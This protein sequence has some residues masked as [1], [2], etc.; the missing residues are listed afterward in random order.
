MT[1]SH[2]H[3]WARPTRFENDIRH[4]F[5]R[6][7]ADTGS[8]SEWTPRVDV[9]EEDARYVIVA[10]VPGV[11]LKDIEISTN[12]NVLTIKGERKSET[13]TENAKLTRI[14]RNYG[15]FERSFT[16][17]EG[18][19]AEAISASGKN[20]VL[21]IAIPKKPQAAPRKIEITH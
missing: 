16:L 15:S 11:E 6:L 10:D 2:Y 8:A 3:P 12:K 20:G 21:E 19:D 13:T 17:P 18:A 5:G 9:R 14:E 7:F 4:V 1:I